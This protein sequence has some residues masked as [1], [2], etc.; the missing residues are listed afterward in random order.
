MRDG[1][2]QLVLASFRQNAW[3][4]GRGDVLEFVDIQIE[5]REVGAHRISAR[6]RCHKELAHDDEPEQIGI[7]LSQTALG[8]I[9]QQNLLVI[10]HLA[11]L[12]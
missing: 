9:H 7:P 4:R 10:N 12:K 2:R 8:K 6:K 5:R 1:E 3:N 11:E